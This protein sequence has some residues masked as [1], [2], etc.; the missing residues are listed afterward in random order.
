MRRFKPSPLP[1]SLLFLSFLS[2][3]FPAWAGSVR[4]VTQIAELTASDGTRGDEVGF[5]LAISGNT[6]AAGAPG[7][8]GSL[9]SGAAYLF[10]KP[11]SGWTNMTQTAE[12]VSTDTVVSLGYSIATNGDTVVGGAPVFGTNELGSEADI[13]V[14][15]EAGW[16]N[17]SQTATLM[18]SNRRANEGF[19]Y[20]TAIGPSGNLVL[21]G[22]PVAGGVVGLYRK[23]A[24]GWENTAQGDVLLPPAGG[25][26]FGAAI[27]IDSTAV[28][29]SD[30][31][32]GGMA[33]AVYIYELVSGHLREV[34]ELTASDGVAGDKF[35]TSVAI[36][37]DIVVAGAPN[38]FSVGGAYVFVKPATGWANMTQT[39]ELIPSSASGG[40]QIGQAVAI[41]G[42]TV[43]VGAPYA[44]VG[45]NANQGAIYGFVEPPSGWANVSE[46]FYLFAS[47]GAAGDRLGY[48][49]AAGNGIVASGA[50]GKNSYE[51]AVYVFSHP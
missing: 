48:S 32:A 42:D 14:A 2:S 51:G 46:S 31:D 6:I 8:L 17:M 33:G 5:S 23:P 26:A 11:N 12:L 38:H 40:S 7:A 10:V 29:V 41:A 50:F 30:P 47:D 9:V 22:V 39:A 43:V 45:A 21:V 19:A 28:L 4:Y 13:Y 25:G 3:P 37:G 1:V 20:T 44:M 18:T 35:G 34:A 16:E 27:A 49:V 24:G 15:G 36:S